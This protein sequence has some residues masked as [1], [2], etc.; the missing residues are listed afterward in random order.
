MKRDQGFFSVCDPDF[1]NP[2]L[3]CRW[4]YSRRPG[5]SRSVQRPWLAQG[6][7][8][9]RVW[10]LLTTES[11]M[12]ARPCPHLL[13]APTNVLPLRLTACQFL[14]LGLLRSARIV[15]G[16]LR[17]LRFALLAGGALALLAF[18]FG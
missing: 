17:L 18:F 8:A 14:H 13:K 9:T 7:M 5:C 4:I 12:G 2:K 10:C 11:G 15:T 6:M 16:L 1:P 3:V